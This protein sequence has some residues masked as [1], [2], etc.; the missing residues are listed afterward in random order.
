MDSTFDEV[1]SLLDRVSHDYGKDRKFVFLIG[2]GVTCPVGNMK[3]VPGVKGVIDLIRLAFSHPDSKEVIEKLDA[4]KGGNAIDEYQQ[5]FR[6]VRSRRGP[7]SVN[8]II[9]QAVLEA[10]IPNDNYREEIELLASEELTPGQSMEPCELLEKDSSHWHLRP[11]IRS[12]GKILADFKDNFGN[13][14]LTTNF[15]PLIRVSARLAGATTEI[16]PLHTDGRPDWATTDL[17]PC[18][19]IHLHGSWTGDT[20]HT[21]V[22][23]NSDRPN[24]EQWLETILANQVLVVVGYGGWDDVFTRALVKINHHP[25]AGHNILWTFFPSSEAEIHA[26]SGSL[27][28]SLQR[29]S[30]GNRVIFYKGV[31][32]D[33]FFPDLLERLH[34]IKNDKLTNGAPP[35]ANILHNEV[36]PA[37]VANI[38]PPVSAEP[39]PPLQQSGIS[40]DYF[41]FL[42]LLKE[43]CESAPQSVRQVDVIPPKERDCIQEPN[44]L[45][46]EREGNVI[47]TIAASSDHIDVHK[48]QKTTEPQ[49]KS[50]QLTRERVKELGFSDAKV[51]PIFRDHGREIHRIY[52]DAA[53]LVQTILFPDSKIALPIYKARGEERKLLAP[54]HAILELLIEWHGSDK[55]IFANIVDR[56]RQHGDNPILK[57]LIDEQSFVTRFAPTPSNPLHLGNV[58]TALANVL[59]SLRDKER[60]R[61]YL[62]FDNTDHTRSPNHIVEK[63]RDE[64]HWLGLRW[65]DSFEQDNA[66]ASR[67]YN[68]LLRVLTLAGFTERGK[69]GRVLLK[70]L[71]SDKYYCVYYD[72]REGPIVTHQ[73]PVTRRGSVF[74]RADLKDAA[75]LIAR[76]RDPRAPLSKYLWSQFSAPAQRKLA[77]AAISSTVPPALQDTLVEE[78]NRVLRGPRLFE[79]KRF[80][81]VKL[82]PKTR[83]L[84]ED[85]LRDEDVALL[86]RLLLED[87]YPHE[88]GKGK[89]QSKTIE[90]SRGDDLNVFYRFA[91]LIDDTRSLWDKDHLTCVLRDYRQAELTHVQAHI[92]FALELARQNLSKHPEAQQLF[93]ECGLNPQ[94]SIPIPL[95]FHLPVVTDNGEIAPRVMRDGKLVREY[96]TLRK[97][98][99]DLEE[100]LEKYTLHYLR[101]EQ[102]VLPETVV[103]Y[104]L[105]T[106]IPR[107]TKPWK[108]HLKLVAFVFSQFGVHAGLQLF[109]NHFSLDDLVR[110]QK[111]IRCVLRHLNLVE[112]VIIGKLP[113]WSLRER[114]KKD[115]WIQPASPDPDREWLVGSIAKYSAEFASYSQILSTLKAPVNKKSISSAR[116]LKEIGAESKDDVE[117]MKRINEEIYRRRVAA[118]ESEDGD[119]EQAKTA[120]VQL[121]KDL[122]LVLTDEAPSPKI[123]SLTGAPTPEPDPLKAILGDKESAARIRRYIVGRKA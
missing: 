7:D 86:N 93:A 61:F 72:R 5:A 23:L 15:D 90:L 94:K 6:H 84:V 50:V 100:G 3:G 78:L 66:I 13:F 102:K 34:K 103:A 98:N 105:A 106:I 51:H 71:P 81:Q 89:T 52:W 10:R 65:D 56:N 83:R 16:W 24:L 25:R 21:D 73:P 67:R 19:I 101:H 48:L 104:L 31:D 35:V 1:D 32:A 28:S 110:N 80:A 18:R 117:M 76:L 116:L 44:F 29:G 114:L 2:S 108:E 99:T 70:P 107:Q 69:G 75:K 119:R 26:T 121:L 36:E 95:Y 77:A 43:R 27:L 54:I 20:L 17:S 8:L 63:I 57:K 45:L 38:V 14:V 64:L 74:S 85:Q 33:I 42:T 111:P 9:R 109:S 118:L 47:M 37:K 87:A 40:Q 82:K 30:G 53:L 59:V 12:L 96:I 58:R 60:S 122:R 11:G 41:D 55:I 112:Q 68:S 39:A 22:V 46:F 92:R 88:F 123:E 4:H 113:A 62:R 120:L 79:K 115:G 91:G 49:I 97:R